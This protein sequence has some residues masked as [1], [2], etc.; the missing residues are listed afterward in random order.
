MRS[1]EEFERVLALVRRGVSDPEIEQLTGIPR[2]T[3]NGWRRNPVRRVLPPPPLPTYWWPDDP[4]SYSYLLGMYLG[5]GCVSVVPR[6]ILLRIVLDGLYTDILDEVTEAIQKTLP[7]VSVCRY[8]RPNDRAVVLQAVSRLWPLVFPQHGKGRKHKRAIVL[9]PWQLWITTA[10]PRELLRGL[11]HSDGCRCV[12]RFSIPLKN[13]RV[14]RY[15]YSRY[16]F[17][18]RS[19]DIL[20]IFGDH[21]DLLGIRWSQTTRQDI[22]IHDRRSVAIMD[23]FVGPKT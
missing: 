5:D 10:Y 14:G 21:C 16:F 13:G 3:I 12:N 11:I 4:E 20:G 8:P 18:N 2:R 23:E 22:S 7:G 1:T 9:Y 6:S 15:A 17:T 19:R